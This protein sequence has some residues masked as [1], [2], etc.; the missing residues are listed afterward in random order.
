ME[1]SHCSSHTLFQYVLV[2]CLHAFLINVGRTV[3][4]PGEEEPFALKCAW[5]RE[6]S[7]LRHLEHQMGAVLCPSLR[8]LVGHVRQCLEQK[9]G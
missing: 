1:P 3:L 9:S 5:K 6:R 4:K 8:Y 7:A 2:F